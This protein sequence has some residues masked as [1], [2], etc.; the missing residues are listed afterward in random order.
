VT[1]GLQETGLEV[2]ANFY[3]LYIFNSLFLRIAELTIIVVMF[4][5]VN[6]S[7]FSDLRNRATNQVTKVLAGAFLTLASCL[8]IVAWALYTTIHVEPIENVYNLTNARIG[9]QVAYIAVYLLSA[10]LLLIMSIAAI[11]R[12]GSLVRIFLQFCRFESFIN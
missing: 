4:L 9:I 3:I 10:A 1:T 5:T 8:T 2:N 6:K 11:F 12:A 7:L